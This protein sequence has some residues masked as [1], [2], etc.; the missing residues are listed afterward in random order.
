[1]NRK[2]GEMSNTETE[3]LL[4]R[5]SQLLAEDK[6]YPL[7]GTLLHAEVRRN[8][9]SPSIFKDRGN[10]IVYRSPDLNRLGDALLDLWEAQEGED[11]WEELQYLVK[12]GRFEVTFVYPEDLDPDEMS[13]DR[14]DKV[15]K[16]YFGDKPVVYPDWDDEDSFVY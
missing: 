5:V 3:R 8:S 1:M 16:Q 6:E 2:E 13:L 4:N 9:V 10:Q 7:E 14:R 12:D 11:R 15:L